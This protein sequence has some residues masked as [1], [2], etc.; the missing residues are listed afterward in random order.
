M[1]VWKIIFLS[2][3]VIC[4]FQPLIFQGVTVGP[5]KKRWEV[6]GKGSCWEFFKHFWKPKHEASSQGE[7]HHWRK[8]RLGW[9]LLAVSCG[10]KL[11]ADGIFV[12]RHL[13]TKQKPDTNITYPVTIAFKW[14]LGMPANGPDT[15]K[16]NLH[17]FF[18]RSEFLLDMQRRNI[19]IYV[20]MFKELATHPP[21][22]TRSI[23]VDIFLSPNKAHLGTKGVNKKPI[24][25]ANM[26]GW[27]FQK[28]K[29]W[30]SDFPQAFSMYVRFQGHGVLSQPLPSPPLPKSSK[31]K[32]L[33][34][35][36]ASLRFWAFAFPTPNLPPPTKKNKGASPDVFKKKNWP[37]S[38]AANYFGTNN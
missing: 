25:K 4:R 36:H 31:T 20:V 9:N 17:E 3:W 23:L 12:S 16:K 18:C 26:T 28:N 24:V 37:C 22:K 6:L 19:Y 30:M 35:C 13:W 29:Q 10:P 15:P 27:N 5:P 21:W 38:S 8:N 2:K 1:E 33:P 7:T 34:S 11:A 32:R 14:L